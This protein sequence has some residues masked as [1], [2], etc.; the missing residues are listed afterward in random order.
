MK[1]SELKQLIRE[2]VIEPEMDPARARRAAEL[3]VQSP[4]AKA[5]ISSD[6]DSLVSNFREN[7]GYTLADISSS[8]KAMQILGTGDKKQLLVDISN[9]LVTYL[10]VH[11]DHLSDLSIEN[12]AEAIREYTD[13]LEN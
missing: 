2:V 5:I 9:Y 1:R 10:I 7:I 3:Y 4:E 12:L 8:E 6:M 13:M 11:L